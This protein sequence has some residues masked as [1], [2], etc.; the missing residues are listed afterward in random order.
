M[1]LNALAHI[2]LVNFSYMCFVN[3]GLHFGFLGTG[4]GNHVDHNCPQKK[5]EGVVF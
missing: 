5:V 1:E 3:N 2:L 4:F